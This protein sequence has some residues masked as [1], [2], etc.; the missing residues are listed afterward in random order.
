VSAVRDTYGGAWAHWTW[1]ELL[2]AVRRIANNAT[3]ASHK[4]E[5]TRWCAPRGGPQLVGDLALQFAGVIGERSDESP[6]LRLDAPAG[7]D[8]LGR[9]VRMRQEVRPRDAAAWR[10]R[11]LEHAEVGATAERLAKRLGAGPVLSTSDADTEQLLG[12]AC[13]WSGASLVCTDAGR[14]ALVDPAVWVCLPGDLTGLTFEA[15]NALQRLGVR[16]RP[17][18]ERIFVVGAVPAGAAARFPGIEVAPWIG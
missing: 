2:V 4:G 3:I 17:R 16:Q 9:L 6:D 10:G 11:V 14:R 12:W 7:S 15:P 1:G 8:D 5:R 13:V 18:L